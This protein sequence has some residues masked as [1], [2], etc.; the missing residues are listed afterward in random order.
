MFSNTGDQSL[1]SIRASAGQIRAA[2]T[3]TS[4]RLTKNWPML[5]RCRSATT[6]A[7]QT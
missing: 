5:T 3:L 1:A 2:R 7:K 6:V 4:R